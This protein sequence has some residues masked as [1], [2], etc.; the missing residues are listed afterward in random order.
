MTGRFVELL[1][2]W[3]QL[4]VGTEGIISG[5]NQRGWVV[6]FGNVSIT[7]PFADEDIVY[8]FVEAHE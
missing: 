2:C 8:R 5:S 1:Q 6:V 3:H 4:P 7:L